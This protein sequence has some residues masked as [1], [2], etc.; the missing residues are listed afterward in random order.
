MQPVAV[1]SRFT[2]CQSKVNDVSIES[3]SVFTTKMLNKCKHLIVFLLL[4]LCTFILLYENK[5]TLLASF[6]HLE[7]L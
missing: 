2:I 7:I 3:S 4:D 5:V 6:A 1:F